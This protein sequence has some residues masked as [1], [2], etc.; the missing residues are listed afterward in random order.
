MVYLV[1]DFSKHLAKE[2]EERDKI[3]WPSVLFQ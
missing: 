1:G 3:L 2:S